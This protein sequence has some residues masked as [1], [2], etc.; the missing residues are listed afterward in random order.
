[1]LDRPVINPALRR[2]W[3]GRGSLQ[4]GVDPSLAMVIDGFDAADER[5]LDLLDGSRD[6]ATAAAQAGSGPERAGEV[7][8]ALRLAGALAEPPLGASLPE[9]MLPDA[10]AA[11]LQRGGE[12]ERT[13]RHRGSCRVLVLGAGRVGATVAGLLAAAGVGVDVV[14]PAPPRP[15]DLAPGGLR[16]LRAVSRGEAARALVSESGPPARSAQGR[17]P[18]QRQPPAP[19]PDL[20]VLAPARANLAPE[21]AAAA[22]GR[23]HLPVLVRETTA[24]IG[25]LVVPGHTACRRCTELRRA[26]RDPQWPWLT[27]Q[28][29]GSGRRVEASD[30]ALAA[31]A[32]ALTALHALRWLDDPAPGEPPAGGHPLI[33][34]IIEVSLHDLRQRRRSVRP[35]PDC[36]C[37]AAA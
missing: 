8:A 5:L 1:M 37:L 12:G 16:D 33:E 3:R 4:F 19:P 23:V 15:G 28:L 26:E 20:V 31:L 22:G 13:L 9:R 29:T 25:P 34:G 18:A 24:A 11:S 17:V 32:A 21:M 35:H 14:D 7:V 6:L 36:G 10:M 30:I 2:L 27:A